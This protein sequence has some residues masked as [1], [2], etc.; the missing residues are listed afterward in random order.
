L[1]PSFFLS[2][3]LPFSLLITQ[4]DSPED[5]IIEKM[6]GP[7]LIARLQANDSTLIR[8]DITA[9][10]LQSLSYP[11]IQIFLA[12]FPCVPS[13]RS[14]HLSG[15]DLEAVLSATQIQELVLGIASM[16]HMQD[17]CIF[18]GGSTALNEEAVAQLLQHNDGALTTLLLFQFASLHECPNLAGALRQHA[19]LQRVTITLPTLLP[20]AALDLYTMCFAVM[21]QLQ[22]LQIRCPGGTPQE[23][24][25]VSPEGFR[26]LISSPTITSLY[27]ENCGLLDDHM[28]VLEE[29]LKHNNRTLQLLDL[30]DNTLLSDDVL[31]SM[32]RVLPHN[33][34]LVSLDLSG[35]Y[36][37]NGGGQALA[38]G[39][40]Q[41]ST[42]THLE[43]EGTEERY[44][45]EFDI[46]LQHDQEEWMKQ[47]YYYLRLNRARAAVEEHEKDQINKRAWVE[48]L[49][50]V[51]DHLDCLYYF[52]RQEARFVQGFN[53]STSNPSYLNYYLDHCQSVKDDEH[54]QQQLEAN[55]GAQMIMQYLGQ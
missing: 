53:S 51:S 26:V 24:P 14:V 15:L 30:K 31:Y 3:N 1:H 19:S 20:Y 5:K 46:Q 10:L 42:V 39:M 17:L 13:I 9:P 29:E 34:T 11:Q 54:R 40:A 43:L 7:D 18:R 21:P 6:N 49:N 55:P 25:L 4:F 38:K 47:I 8:L 28:D 41:N 36:I 48:K 35:V 16:Q 27:L 22:V 45:N 12:T 32:G 44:R 2:Y 33:T 50:R 23:E 52:I 37:S